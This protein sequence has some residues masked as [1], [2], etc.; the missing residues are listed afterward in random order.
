MFD[1]DVEKRRG[2][3]SLPLMSVVNP[4][5]CLTEA[6]SARIRDREMAV[7]R[8]YQQAKQPVDPPLV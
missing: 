5:R 6:A 7:S 3:A 4:P 1:N 2:N 8:E